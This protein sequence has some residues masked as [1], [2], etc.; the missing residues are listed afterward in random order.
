MHTTQ[1]ICDGDKNDGL[2][3][4]VPVGTPVIAPADGVVSARWNDKT[5]GCG[6]TVMMKFPDGSYAGFA[7][8]SDTRV[9]VGQTVKQGE[10]IAHS[11][12]TGNAPSPELH[13]TVFTPGGDKIDPRKWVMSKPPQPDISAIADPNVLEKAIQAAQNGPESPQ[14][15]KQ[16]IAELEA[17]H[18]HYRTIENQKYD[19]NLGKAVNF[20][21]ANSKNWRK[22][23]S[24]VWAKLN[25]AD[26]GRLKG[27][28][29]PQTIFRR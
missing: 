25:D 29:D 28:I 5:Y 16:I 18:A 6:L 19:D 22:I 2:D 17:E 7:W 23:P 1:P 4:S 8:L 24:D 27:G 20:W 12:Q 3:I 9:E 10:V 21:Y 14:I 13:Y 11:G 15:K 26:K